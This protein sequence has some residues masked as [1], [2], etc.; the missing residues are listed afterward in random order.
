MAPAGPQEARFVSR[1]RSSGAQLLFTYANLPQQQH[2]VI[3]PLNLNRRP[4][5]AAADGRRA[6]VH[7]LRLAKVRC[8]SDKRTNTVEARLCCV[9]AHLQSFPSVSIIF[10]FR[11]IWLFFSL[12]LA[13]RRTQLERCSVKVRHPSKTKPFFHSCFIPP[14]PTQKNKQKLECNFPPPLRAN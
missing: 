1:A 9:R 14:T 7:L 3:H 4:T 2:S 13:G 5:E 12:A 10:H 6:Q 8:A 11:Y